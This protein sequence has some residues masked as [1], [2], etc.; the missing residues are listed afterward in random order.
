MRIV[1]FDSQGF[2]LFLNP[3]NYN[4]ANIT[5]TFTSLP[6]ADALVGG[7]QGGAS[8]RPSANQRATGGVVA[9]QPI[10][11][12]DGEKG[13]PRD[14]TTPPGQSTDLPLVLANERATS[15][16]ARQVRECVVSHPKMS[17]L[18]SIPKYGH[19]SV[20]LDRVRERATPERSVPESGSRGANRGR[21]R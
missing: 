11:P 5:L 2:L 15:E 21:E 8:R 17:G 7:V 10:R 12:R 4:N 19:E 14:V 18:N 16:S 20:R 3:Q 6:H 13:G 1:I 9:A